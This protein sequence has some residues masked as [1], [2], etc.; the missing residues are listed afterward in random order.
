MYKRQGLRQGC[1]LSR[2]LFKVYL[3]KALGK[4]STKV[5]GMGLQVGKEKLFS[6]YFADDQ[7]VIAE[8]LDDLSYMIRK[9]QEE[10]QLAGLGINMNKSEYIIVGNYVQDNLDLGNI[11]IKGVSTCKYLGVTLN[12]QGNSSDEIK[13]RLNKG[14]K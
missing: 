4:W 2:T 13:E 3:D 9:L 1:S 10:Y 11:T 5:R 14:E 8:D 6:S 7:V 12:K